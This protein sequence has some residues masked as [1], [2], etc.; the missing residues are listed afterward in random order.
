[1]DGSVPSNL[2]KLANL[3][4]K[5]EGPSKV[6]VA[7]MEFMVGRERL[8]Q[9]G[10]IMLANGYLFSLLTMQGDKYGIWYDEQ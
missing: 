2:R 6:L 5:E 10:L 9:R 1:M 7:S 8:D 3:E 4:S